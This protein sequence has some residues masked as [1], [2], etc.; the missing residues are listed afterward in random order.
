M[1]KFGFGQPLKRKEDDALLRGAGRYIA[2]VMPEGALQAVVLRS[3]YAHARFRI[4]DLDR[5]REM[6]GV[7]LVLT[8]EDV[9]HLNPMPTP[10]VGRGARC[11]TSAPVSTSRTP[12]M[13]RTRAR[14]RI[15]NFACACGE[16]STTACSAP[17]GMTSA[18]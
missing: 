4:H 10:G 15:E 2:D 5:V 8:G 6:P 9:A 12:F 13:A 7:R 16:R 17:S 14:S 11:A 3:P 1:A 18:M